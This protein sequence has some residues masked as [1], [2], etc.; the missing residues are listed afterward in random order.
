MSMKPQEISPVPEETARVARAANP[1]SNVYM[2]MRDEL[3]SIYEDQMFVA[4]FPRRGQPAEAPWRLALVTVMQYMEGLSDRQEALAV[5][6]RIDWKYALSLELTDPGFDFS[7]LSEFRTRRLSGEAETHLLQVLL[8]LCKS[9]GWRN[10]TRTPAHRFDAC[11]GRY[12]RSESARVR[13]GDLAPRAQCVG[14]GSSGLAVGSDT[15]GVVRTLQ[16][17]L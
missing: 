2:H 11:P 5:R 1:K 4:L 3:G 17:P 9:R 8:D 14:R 13:G 12:S 7:L 6:E 15:T 16:S 10:R